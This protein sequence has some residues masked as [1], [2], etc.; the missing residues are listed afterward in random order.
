MRPLPVILSLRRIRNRAGKRLGGGAMRPQSWSRLIHAGLAA[1]LVAAC[2]PTTG[3]PADAPLARSA[4]R[5]PDPVQA[6]D[7]PV[8]ETE[9]RGSA[10]DWERAQ[11]AARA[12]GTVSVVTHPSLQWRGW[13]PIFQQRFPDIKVEHLGMRPSEVTPRIISEQRNGV[14]AFDVMVGP[15]S[16]SVKNLAPAGV[17]Q[18]LR[19][20]LLSP[21]SVDNA[22]WH[23]GLEMWADKEAYYSLVT[24]MTVTRAT[25]VN[26][27]MVPRGQFLARSRRVRTEG[28]SQRV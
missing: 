12:E 4:E 28:V 10:A 16:N 26:R 21:E 8:R 25:I 7:I 22:K 18:D 11:V 15:T 2:A 23:G 1:M 27:R 9:I 3:R 20:L 6:V 17:F 14:F 19:P 5:Q 13:V 24:A